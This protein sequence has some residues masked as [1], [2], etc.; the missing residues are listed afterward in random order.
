MKRGFRILILII[1]C[2]IGFQLEAFAK[3]LWQQADNIKIDGKFN[4]W[5]GKPYIS[6]YKHD[7]RS[8]WL[9]FLKVSYFADDRYLYLYVERQSAKQSQ[10][11]DFEVVIL[12]AKKRKKYTEEIPVE[13]YSNNNYY[14]PYDFEEMKFA[15]FNVSSNYKYKRNHKLIPITVSFNDQDIETTLS[16]DMNNKKIEFRI[17]LEKVGLE[18]RNKEVEFMIKSDFD[19]KA[20]EKGKYTFDWVPNGKAIIITT[21]PTYWQMS[22]VILF[23]TVSFIVYRIYR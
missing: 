20:Y 21:G 15:K 14:E 18:G 6:D 4:D 23:I 1:L 3:P 5:K 8:A 9:N 2:T 7:I 17:P 13:Y 22:A 11:W 19:E 10:D 12:N 16:G